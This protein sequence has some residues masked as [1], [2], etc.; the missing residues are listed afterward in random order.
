[1]VFGGGELQDLL[2][3]WVALAFCFSAG[4]L[5]TP[6]LPL[7]FAMA[8]VTVGASFVAHELAHKF[9]ARRFGCWAGF[10]LWGW[11]L[12]LAL[13]LAM[14]SR[15]RI[16]FA[17]PGAVYIVPSARAFYRGWLSPRESGLIA[18][19]GPTANVALALAFLC[20]SG[21]GGILGVVG[22]R[23]FQVNAWLAAFNMLPFYPLDGW[24]VYSWSKLVW[25][26]IAIPLWIATF[27][28]VF[29]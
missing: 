2:I 10:R 14:V 24:K 23:G 3:A 26:A 16:I 4:A 27:W 15:G 12:I 8:L 20:M 1:M 5:L 17:A 7:V 6:R 22:A 29:L 19:S 11:G 25:V 28:L 18:L 9:V 21:L 13:I